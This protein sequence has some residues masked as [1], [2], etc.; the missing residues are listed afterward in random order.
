M[1]CLSEGIKWVCPTKFINC[2]SVRTFVRQLTGKTCGLAHMYT[3]H[4]FV[5]LND[6]TEAPKKLRVEFGLIPEELL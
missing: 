5:E 4:A 1:I 6:E 2:D 3:S